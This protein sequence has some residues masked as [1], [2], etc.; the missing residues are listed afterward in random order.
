MT[1]PPEYTPHASQIDGVG[2]VDGDIAETI[3]RSLTETNPAPSALGT[4]ADAN[5]TVSGAEQS[6]LPNEDEQLEVDIAQ[7]IQLS[8]SPLQNPGLPGSS[9]DS[10]PLRSRPR[11]RPSQAVQRPTVSEY[12]VQGNRKTHPHTPLV[13]RVT[14]AEF[15]AQRWRERG[16]RGIIRSLTRNPNP[17]ISNLHPTPLYSCPRRRRTQVVGGHGPTV[18]EYLAQGVRREHTRTRYVKRVFIFEF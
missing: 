3:L 10:A 12:M 14:I 8:L 18:S 13:K 15:L 16:A 9:K 4:Q 17:P 6:P 1:P 11:I 2:E 7:A 5:T